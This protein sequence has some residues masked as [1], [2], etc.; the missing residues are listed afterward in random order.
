MNNNN[1]DVK[2]IDSSGVGLTISFFVLGIF[3]WI[4]PDFLLFESLSINIA[5]IFLI[6]SIAFLGQTTKNEKKKDIFSNI[7][8]GMVFIG[9]FV[10]WVDSTNKISNQSFLFI[11]RLIFLI[12]LL[13]GVFGTMVGFTEHINSLYNSSI[14]KTDKYDNEV[15]KTGSK[16]NK[17][18]FFNFLF[19]LIG[20]AAA[21]ASIYQ[22]VSNT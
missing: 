4:K 11:I 5:K 13:I 8:V 22:I 12:I 9:V 18:E 16:S 19:Q 20:A 3:L 15:K 6:L 14:K 1:P 7:S 10:A 2:G 21:I 17:K